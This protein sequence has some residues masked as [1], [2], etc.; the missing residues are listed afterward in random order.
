MQIKKRLNFVYNLNK[1]I[2][3]LQAQ[4]LAKFSFEDNLFVLNKKQ[5][6]IKSILLYLDDEQMMHLGDHLFFEPLAKH[7]K[8]SGFELFIHPT[9]I[10]EFYFND[11]GYEIDFENKLSKYDLIITC[12]RLYRKIKELKN[13]ILLIDTT[14]TKIKSPICDDMVHKVSRFLGL[15]K[16]LENCIP[17]FLNSSV[18]NKKFSFLK[19]NEKYIIF[20]NYIDSGKIRHGSTYQKLLI[21]FIKNLK[22]NTGF[23]V[24]HTGSSQ[25]KVDD[26][27]KYD[28]VDY[29]IRGI[30]SIKD[31]FGICAQK[32][33]IY[34]VSFDA[35]QMHLFFILNKKSFIL[36]RGRIFKK[37]E[38]FVKKFV[39]P[40]FIKPRSDLLIE[41]IEDSRLPLEESLVKNKFLK[42]KKFRDG[43]FSIIIPCYN[44]ERY[45]ERCIK[46]IKNQT[47][48]KFEALLIDDGSSD[49]SY[50][51]FK[52]NTYGDSR[53]KIIRHKKNLGLSASRN[54][55]IMNST[56]E[57]IA[58]LD[59]DDWWPKT[60]LRVY[61]H[62]FLKGS[63]LLFSDYT[64]V[65][66]I[67]NR[68][69]RVKKNISFK[70]LLASNLIP[71]SS[72][73]FNQ[74]KTG[75]QFFKY[76]SPSEDWLFWLNLIKLS[77]YPLGISKNLMFY[78]VS[79]DSMSANKLIMARRAW[80]IFRD[81]HRF[82]FY[83]SAY[84]FLI[85]FIRGLKVNFL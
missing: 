71:V 30:S 84:Y 4:K 40:P 54:S 11:L 19:K 16:S 1:I 53:F 5:T 24:I 28:F 63:D 59:I 56:G 85:Y 20:N 69:I 76:K 79:N 22:L 46:S 12:S 82:N 81:Y 18:N 39:N 35:F 10:M 15:E 75:T 80:Y 49:Q 29:D 26:Y 31:I 57:Y 72:S 70:M 36:F 27:T 73:A 6:K 9:K 47:Y 17:T 8:L 42:E 74:M 38:D 2:N 32:N 65:N 55:G 21:N 13:Q 34:N 83:K 37:N 62:Y 78:N 48:R 43:F 14:S 3:E 44:G 61:S 67:K 52:K 33:V 66:G 64:R 60:K 41:Y 68:K 58:F 77:K 23:K 51:V 50:E 25:D 7:L 45:V